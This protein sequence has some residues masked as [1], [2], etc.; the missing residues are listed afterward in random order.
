MYKPN[1]T[2]LNLLCEHNF[3]LNF[4]LDGSLKVFQYLIVKH[5]RVDASNNI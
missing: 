4:A 5:G 2:E 3:A 1:N